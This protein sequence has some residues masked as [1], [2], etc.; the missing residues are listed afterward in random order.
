MVA[1][2][3]HG[4]GLHEVRVVGR[5][6]ERTFPY[7][8]EPIELGPLVGVRDQRT[9]DDADAGYAK[10]MLNLMPEGPGSKVFRARPALIQL[11]EDS[12]LGI[13]TS[14][15][16]QAIFQHTR[17]DGVEYSF[18]FVGGKLYEYDWSTDTHVLQPT[19]GVVIS[20][21]TH[22]YCATF[23]DFM[24]VHD[25]I[26]R[27]WKYDAA[28]KVA[29]YLTDMPST[30][31]GPIAV[32]GSSAMFILANER[33]VF[34]YSNILDP[35]LGYEPAN[36]RYILGQTDQDPLYAL[37]GT[38]SGLYYFRASSIGIITG[39]VDDEFAVG[40]STTDAVSPRR[41]TRSPGSIYSDERGILF[42]DQFGRPARID[43]GDTVRPLHGDMFATV[44]EV[45]RNALERVSVTVVP[46]ADVALFALP[47][48]EERSA[49]QAAP[50]QLFAVNMQGDAWLGFW[51]APGRA[52]VRAMGMWKDSDRQERTVLGTEDGRL[53]LMDLV[54]S[55]QVVDQVGGFDEPIPAE[56]NF[57]AIG[58]EGD[59][60]KTFDTIEI[61]TAG[62]DV[63]AVFD[64]AD[65]TG[66][67]AGAMP[68]S[69]GRKSI[70]G[71]DYTTRY[72][73]P[74]LRSSTSSEER[75][76]FSGAVVRGQVVGNDP[77]TY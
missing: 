77:E 51:E 14:R 4:P 37:H 3:R 57:G 11:D 31:Y 5:A 32:Y 43:P 30:A 34:V 33:N 69:L 23:A 68:V 50:R 67:R 60:E 62:R 35:D 63:P 49:G 38:N 45:D 39:E 40:G 7:D 53:F 16:V 59:L 20:P 61:Y 54:E 6:E 73:E 65:A 19:V 74:E 12:L 17:L 10:R 70:L 44:K 36:N 15:L 48:T 27:P 52:A 13:V 26:N 9:A 22:V 24:L 55:G 41:G 2:D 21:L 58:F 28:T 47:L 1:L 56:I 64:C 46:D 8:F 18:T 42:V 76:T 29:S 72:I 25:G 66:W 71:L 75:F